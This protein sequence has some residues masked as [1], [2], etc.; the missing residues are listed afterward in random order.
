MVGATNLV[1]QDTNGRDDVFVRGRQAGQS[2]RASAASDGPCLGPR[3]AIGGAARA[4][5]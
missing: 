2:T 4:E 1:A 3:S 5:Q